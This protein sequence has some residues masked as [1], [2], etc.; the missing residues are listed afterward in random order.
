[1]VRAS[2]RYERTSCGTPID[3]G[4]LSTSYGPRNGPPHPPRIAT[5]CYVHLGFVFV[6][7]AERS[8]AEGSVGQIFKCLKRL[9]DFHANPKRAGSV[10]KR[11]K[12][13]GDPNWRLVESLRFACRQ[14]NPRKPKENW[15]LQQPSRQFAISWWRRECDWDPNRTHCINGVHRPSA[16]RLRLADSAG[17]IAPSSVTT[18]AR[19]T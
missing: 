8:P 7:V 2:G 19:S 12:G 11:R 5:L 18:V 15:P 17:K 16:L 13:F 10:G 9:D 4:W 3:A 14:Q 6:L 1:M